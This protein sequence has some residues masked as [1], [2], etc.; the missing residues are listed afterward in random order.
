[1]FVQLLSIWDTIS[2]KC[3]PKFSRN[4]ILWKGY[5]F[6]TMDKISEIFYPRRIK[7][8]QKCYPPDTIIG[9]I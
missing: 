1:M 3:Y 5:Y 6:Y 9:R 2:E 8:V 7:I 4:N